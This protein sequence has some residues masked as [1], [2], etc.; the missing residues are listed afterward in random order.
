MAHKHSF[1]IEETENKG[2]KRAFQVVVAAKEIEADTDAEL[3][4]VGKKVKIPGFRPGKVPANVLKQKY[5]KSVLGDV[6]DHLVDHAVRDVLDKYKIVPALQPKV[7]IKDFKEGGD[8]TIAMSLEVMPEAP[9]ID[10][11]KITI[12][13]PVYEVG[14]EEVSEAL[15]GLAKNNRTLKEKSGAAAKG[16][17]VKID[18]K[19]FVDGEA[20]EGG[21]AKNFNL[22]LGSGQ[23][24]EGFEDQ[25]IGIKAGDKKDVNVTFP[26]QYHK[27]DLKGKKAKFEVK[28]HAVQSPEDAAIDDDF[29]QKFGMESKDK[30]EEMIKQQLEN[31]YAGAARTQLKKQ[32]FDELEKK[33]D[34]EI[35]AGM[36]KLEFDSIWAQIQEA[37]KQGDPEFDKSDDELKKEYDAVARRRVSLGILLSQTAGKQN[38]QVS[39]EDLRQAILNQARMYPGQERAVI[40]FYNKN[41]NEVNQ[42]RGPILEEKAVDYI[43]G[44]VKYT[45]KKVSRDELLNPDAISGKKSSKKSA[46]KDEDA[47]PKAESKAKKSGKK[48]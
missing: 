18:F 42:F 45:E 25:L 1:K 12:E 20:F 44:K 37:K 26:K 28:V 32:L 40:E 5:G 24:I 33:C 31:D 29:A 30:L 41:P 46:G 17:V 16:D 10:F 43:L 14:K 15:S 36:L 13:K 11:T 4:K 38:L 2:L 48:E 27:E 34:F 7:E 22:E 47:S 35:P 21:E 9:A 23:F 6:I 19:G 39:T 8:L 3:V